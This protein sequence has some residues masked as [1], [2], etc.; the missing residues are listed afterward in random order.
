MSSVHLF[1]LKSHAYCAPSEKWRAVHFPIGLSLIAGVLKEKNFNIR[2]FDNY[3]DK[4]PIKDLLTEVEKSQP[5]YL[6]FTG[7]L[8]NQQYG[9]LK[10]IS[11]RLSELC[12]RS[13]QI[14]GGPMATTIPAILLK[15]YA[16]D[17]VVIGE[18]E[19]TILDLLNALARGRALAEVKGIAFRDDQGE[20]IIT[21]KRPRI[22]DF[23]TM[24]R[25]PYELFDMGYY[26][27]YLRQTGRCW[28]LTA[29]RGCIGHCTYCKLVFGRELSFRPIEQIIDDMRFMKQQYG[30]DRFNFVDDNFLNVDKKVD[31]FISAMKLSKDKFK[32]RFQGRV[33]KVDRAMARKLREI[34]CFG[35]SFG[36]ESGSDKIL[37]NIRKRYDI[38]KAEENLKAVLD[39]GL[40]VHATFI[41]GTPLEDESTI[42]ATKQFIRRVGLPNVD[43][44]ILA[45]FPGTEVYRLAVQR[46]LIKDEDAYCEQLGTDT[47]NVFETVMINLTQ[48]PDETL[49]R[50]R[51][52][53][54]KLSSHPH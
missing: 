52:E 10:D 31:E 26:M 9:F 2:V 3:S 53:I 17:Y 12:P 5:D 15:N 29:S 36:L 51:D 42:E 6:M 13:L 47:D 27:E 44:M 39:E 20:V 16:V 18:G 45:P 54:N 30:I 49:I 14:F 41:V 25:P 35:I 34:G 19:E 40:E 22:R 23:S 50:W 1:N 37:T 4:L 38:K 46:G 43:A 28:E 11:H 48:Y 8:G 33:D 24:P 21:D 7:F 32:F